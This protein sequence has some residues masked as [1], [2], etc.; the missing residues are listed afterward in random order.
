MD[1]KKKLFGQFPPVSTAEWMEK[2]TADLEGAD[3]NKRLVWKTRA[4]LSVMPFYRQEDLEGLPHS[5]LLPGDFPF[6]RGV[7]VTGNRWLVRQDII[8]TDYSTANGKAL[9]ILMRGITSLG[10]V[11]IDPETVTP[12]NIA[13]LLNGIHPESVELNFCV[14]G[15]AK[16]LLAALKAWLGS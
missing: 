15:K 13:R 9:D 3:V 1:K 10:F 6:V 11:I 16:E 4:G 12:E 5:A 2:I 14:A 7:Q 8:V